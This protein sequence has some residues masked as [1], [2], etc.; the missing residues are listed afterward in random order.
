M[1]LGDAIRTLRFTCDETQREFAKHF[2]IGALTISRWETAGR[3]PGSR[4][5]RP[6]W[7]LARKKNREDLAQIFDKEFG[8]RVGLTIAETYARRQRARRSVDSI[9]AH[10]QVA[11]EH[12]GLSEGVRAHLRDIEQNGSLLKDLFSELEVA[13]AA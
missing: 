11:L 2:G 12:P 8:A 6:L 13:E 5:F 1:N 3:H 7:R 4:Y 9:I 10:A